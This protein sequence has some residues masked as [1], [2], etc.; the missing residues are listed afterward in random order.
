MRVMRGVG[1]LAVAFGTLLYGASQKPIPESGEAIYRQ[2]CG[3][4]HGLDGKA[5]TAIGKTQKMRDLTSPEVQ[6]QTDAVL[7]RVIARGKGYMP[8]YELILGNERIQ[9]VIGYV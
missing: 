4:C 2:K 6:K 8:P 5:D 9:A 7:T 1:I 3:G